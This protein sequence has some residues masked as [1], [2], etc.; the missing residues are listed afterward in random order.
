IL[1]GIGRLHGAV[2]G[3]AAYVLLQE[4]FS[5]SALFGAYAKHWQLFMGGLIIFIVLA[6]PHGIGG[7]IDVAWV[8]RRRRGGDSNAESGDG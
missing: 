5:S 1:G 4:F 2:I 7:L 6:L 8:A 3:A